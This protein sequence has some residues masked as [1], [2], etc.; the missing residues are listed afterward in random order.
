MTQILI[1]DDDPNIQLLL[2][3]ALKKSGYNIASANNGEEGFQ[4]AKE[5]KPALIISDWLMPGLSGLELCRKV[6]ETKEFATTFFILLTSRVSVED[7]VQGLD[8]GADDFICKPIDLQELQ[9]RVRAGLRLHQLS[10]DL[11]KQKQLLEAELAEAA[12]YVS[13]ILPESLTHSSLNIDVYFIPSRQLGGDSFDYFW[14]DSEH[15][16][17]YLLDVSGH[18][19]RAALPSISVINLLR[20]GSLNNV[21]YYDPSE[22][23]EGLNNIFQITERNNK[24]FT[25]WYGVYNILTRELSYSSAGHPPAILLSFDEKKQEIT[26]KKLKTKGIPIGMFPDLTYQNN[27][28]QIPLQSNLYLFSDGI[29][30]LK[31]EDSQIWG[32]D[33]FIKILK[34]HQNPAENN[35]AEI[36]K[37]VKK[38]NLT[39]YFEDD[40]SI[41]EIKFKTYPS[42]PNYT[43]DISKNDNF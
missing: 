36:L 3:R 31:Q 40:I 39:E 26:E 41:M 27:S 1:I 34:L 30:E 16:V 4:L 20:S 32:L 2:T 38:H 11:R 42:S 9:A 23:L 25:I 17:M 7:R 15:L 13:S 14:L 35:L 12:D 8:A 10:Q 21:N 28:C 33:N 22:V 24:Y 43:I 18:G 6:K 29:Y 5:I 37:A 19:L